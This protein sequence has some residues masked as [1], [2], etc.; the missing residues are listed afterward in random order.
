MYHIEKITGRSY[1]IVDMSNEH[2]IKVVEHYLNLLSKISFDSNIR[3]ISEF[4]SKVQML[5]PYLFALIGRRLYTKD[6][7]NKLEKLYVFY[8]RKRKTVSYELLSPV[9]DSNLID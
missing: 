4:E 8:E 3:Y 6:Y 1:P 5:F 9:W 2:I 7:E